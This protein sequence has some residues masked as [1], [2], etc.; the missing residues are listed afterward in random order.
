[1][2]EIEKEIAENLKLDSI[3]DIRNANREVRKILL[4][5]PVDIE[6]PIILKN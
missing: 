2:K 3:K 5:Q 1:L 6:K 4:T